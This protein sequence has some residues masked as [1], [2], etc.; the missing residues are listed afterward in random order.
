MKYKAVSLPIQVDDT[1]CYNIIVLL[2]NSAKLF[3]KRQF[4]NKV[5]SETFVCQI[6]VYIYMNI[7]GNTIGIISSIDEAFLILNGLCIT[8]NV[9]KLCTLCNFHTYPLYLSRDVNHYLRF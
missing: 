1:D 4:Q 8:C 6:H 5:S 9:Y 2:D 3:L 7:Y